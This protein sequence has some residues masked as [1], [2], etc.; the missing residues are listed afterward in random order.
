VREG[1]AQEVRAWT[2]R[3]DRSQFDEEKIEIDHREHGEGET[4]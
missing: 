1:K 4:K 3:E 2:V